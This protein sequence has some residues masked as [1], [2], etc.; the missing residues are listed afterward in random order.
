[1][2][3]TEETMKRTLLFIVGYYLILQAAIGVFL[4][5]GQPENLFVILCLSAVFGY[6]GYKL[7]QRT[8]R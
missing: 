8:H 6:F 4:V 5:C 7:I 3:A 2:R 1:M